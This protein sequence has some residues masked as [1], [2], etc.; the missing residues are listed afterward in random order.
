MKKY[1]NSFAIIFATVALSS[2]LKEKQN[3]DPSD[4]NAVIEIGDISK[5]VNFAASDLLGN[6]YSSSFDIV[7]SVDFSIPIVYTGV[8]NAPED[9]TVTLEQN[10]SILD[11]YNTKFDLS[12]DDEDAYEI[13]STD[14]YT[15]PSLT[16]TIPKGQKRANLVVSLKTDKF[17]FEKFYAF[18]FKIKSVSSGIISGNF[19]TAM[20]IV[21]AKNEYEADYASKGFLFHPSQPRAFSGTKHIATRGLKRCQVDLGDLGGSGYAYQ[22]TVSASNALT[23]YAAVGAAPAAPASGFMTADN[24]GKTVYPGTDQPGSGEWVQSKYNNTYDPATKTFFLHAGYA[25]GGNGQSTFTR[26][27]YDMLVR[28]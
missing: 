26:Q 16:V 10:Q 17:S 1:I 20:F 23:D 15:M 28:K 9:I 3:F 8:G 25:S 2:C 13:P 18:G 22:F 5:P 24:P 6:V 7:P 14:L 19:N 11:Q 21:A 4:T 27:S 12:V